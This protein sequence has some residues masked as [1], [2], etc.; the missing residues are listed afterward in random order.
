MGH[1]TCRMYSIW[2]TVLH[3]QQW[4]YLG[5]NSRENCLHGLPQASA[6]S[7]NCKHNRTLSSIQV[8][9][10]MQINLDQSTVVEG[11]QEQAKNCGD[12]GVLH[13]SNAVLTLDGLQLDRWSP[14]K[15]LLYRSNYEPFPRGS[16][17]RQIVHKSPCNP[18]VMLI[19]A[20]FR[21]LDNNKLSGILDIS[22]M[23]AVGL[24]QADASATKL[25]IMSL[26]NNSIHDVISE[27][28][29]IASVT[30]IFK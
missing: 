7:K 15:W 20:W 22:Q 11:F 13:V 10:A 16:D 17:A 26:I 25:K 6:L 24:L 8:D 2:L 5:I 29:I 3:W 27:P 30:A 18:S 21:Y 4:T 14:N 12:S 19:R 1:S 9:F 28:H 23:F